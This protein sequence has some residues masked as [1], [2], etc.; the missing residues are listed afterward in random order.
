MKEVGFFIVVAVLLVGCRIG[1]PAAPQKEIAPQDAMLDNWTALAVSSQGHGTTVPSTGALPLSTIG[2]WIF[3]GLPED[4][5]R[6]VQCS[7]DD[8]IR[9]GVE[10]LYLHS[11]NGMEK[12]R[13][14]K[15]E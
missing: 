1:N 2:P 13:R 11:R 12:W 9:D 5:P 8:A 15:F 10:C 7:T 14:C 4:D 6:H 3:C